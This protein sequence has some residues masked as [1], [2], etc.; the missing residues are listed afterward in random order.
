[1]SGPSPLVVI[2]GG[3]HARI[4]IDCARSQPTHWTIAGYS[5]P[6]ASDETSRRYGIAWLGD[7]D[8]VLGRAPAGALFVL[9]LGGL[10][11]STRRQQLA[12]RFAAHQVR[13]ATVVHAHA[14]I[15]EH[16]S[17]GE[18]VVVFAGAVVNSGAIV[19]AHAIVN[20]GAIV[21]HDVHVGAFSFLAPGCVVGGGVTIGDGAFVGLGSRVRDHVRIGARALVAMGA[22]VVADVADDDEVLGVPARSRRP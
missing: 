6:T 19:G 13:W 14:I 22:V 12:A 21:E 10:S 9:G 18:G 20:S 7:D 8:A 5:D 15:S 16:A 11:P 3:E 4:V 2:G 1:M 17:L